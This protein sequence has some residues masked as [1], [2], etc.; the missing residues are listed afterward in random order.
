MKVLVAGAGIIGNFVAASLIDRGL[1]VEMVDE[2]PRPFLGSSYAAF[3][4]LTP[5]SDPFFR[6]DARRFA[7]KSVEMYRQSWIP[8]LN[9]IPDV[10]VDL[11]D[12]GLIQLCSTSEEF[13]Q[14][15]AHIEDLTSSGYLARVLSRQEVLKLEPALAGKYECGIWLDEPWLD[16]DALYR[17][18]IAFLT[19]SSRFRTLF[20]T[21]LRSVEIDNNNVASAIFESGE[22]A[23]YDFVVLATGVN[24]SNELCN[25]PLS[26]VRGDCV[27]VTTSNDI[28]LLRR[29]V[30]M[31]EGFITPRQTGQMLLGATYVA[32]ARDGPEAYAREHR[33]Q[34]KVP[35]LLALLQNNLAIVPGLGDCDV[36]RTWRG[37]RPTLPDNMPILG[38]SPLS[39]RLIVANGF[40]GLGLTMAPGV[41]DA[42]ARYILDGDR[43]GFPIT[44]SAE[45]FSGDSLE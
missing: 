32:E 20:N 25:L 40:I 35:Q 34:I 30:Y 13:S 19:A 2:Q 8:A 17:A 28:P 9:R 31:H 22:R 33:D 1:D 24:T 27:L 10:S 14:Y 41:G 36:I 37:W 11:H 18:L 38:P 45:R 4:S 29:H 16:R 43:S 21:R 5:F 23:S 42:I 7:A 39:S 44:F 3:G 15:E 6:G 12:E 26:W